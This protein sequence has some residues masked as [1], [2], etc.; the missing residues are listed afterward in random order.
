[1]TP[2]YPCPARVVVLGCACGLFISEDEDGE[3]LAAVRRGEII[4]P[5]CGEVATISSRERCQA[6]HEDGATGATY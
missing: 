6:S 2:N 5:T 4:C 1:M 3:L